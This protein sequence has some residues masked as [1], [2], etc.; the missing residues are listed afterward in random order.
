MLSFKRFCA[1]IASK[2]GVTPFLAR[3]C[4]AI[5]TIAS[6][7]KNSKIDFYFSMSPN[8]KSL[9]RIEFSPSWDF[10]SLS[11][12]RISSDTNLPCISPLPKWMETG[13]VSPLPFLNDFDLDWLKAWCDCNA[14]Y[15]KST[16]LESIQVL[17]D[18]VSNRAISFWGG[19][20]M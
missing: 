18:P 4:C 12:I 1:I 11:P 17:A 9:I 5:P 14:Y 8:L 19:L 16:L 15:G 13:L 6:N 20:P 10:S 2:I 7:W 3:P